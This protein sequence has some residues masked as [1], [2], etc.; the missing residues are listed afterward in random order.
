MFLEA[1]KS[2]Y[3]CCFTKNTSFKSDFKLEMF[4]YVSELLQNLVNDLGFETYG[5]TL[6]HHLKS[7]SF[8][9]T[10]TSLRSL[11]RG[12]MANDKGAS[13]F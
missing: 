10:G 5:G 2:A 8:D 9:L 1:F 7:V 13:I 6:F 11:R 12:I 3:G 4:V